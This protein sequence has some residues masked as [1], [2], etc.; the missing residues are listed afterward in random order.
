[1][2]VGLF[3]PRYVRLSFLILAG[4]TIITAKSYFLLSA[5]SFIALNGTRGNMDPVLLLI[6]NDM[7]NKRRGYKIRGCTPYALLLISCRFD[8][9]L[10]EFDEFGHLGA[11][12]DE[13]QCA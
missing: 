7:E 13:C 2:S 5:D 1:M 10:A 12:F 6:E 4:V 8:R 11:A 3:L 9:S